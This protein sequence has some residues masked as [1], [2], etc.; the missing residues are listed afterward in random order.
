MKKLGSTCLCVALVLFCASVHAG[1]VS[2]TGADGNDG[3]ARAHR[4]QQ[5][6]ASVRG[7]KARSVEHTPAMR[8][9]RAKHAPAIQRLQTNVY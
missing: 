1:D 5:S 2:S 6:A 8:R 3:R 7:K 4:N 9:A